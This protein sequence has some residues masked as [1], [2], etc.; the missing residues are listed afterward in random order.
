MQKYYFYK[1]TRNSLFHMA[2]SRSPP[3]LS[4]PPP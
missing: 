1:L 3:K 4:R 2:L